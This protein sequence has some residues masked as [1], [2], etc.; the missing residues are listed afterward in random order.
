MGVGVVQLEVF[1][2]HL[3]DIQNLHL[4]DFAGGHFADHKERM[5]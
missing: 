5:G 4:E 1:P 2:A 3:N